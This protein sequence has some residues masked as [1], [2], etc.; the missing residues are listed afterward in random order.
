[1]VLALGVNFV[2]ITSIY[3]AS[4]ALYKTAV[5]YVPDVQKR[6]CLVLEVLTPL[7][8]YAVGVT[9]LAAP[10]IRVAS[11]AFFAPDGLQMPSFVAEPPAPSA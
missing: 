10:Y 11:L 6:A 4:H 3:R 1:M 5:T 2:E 9:S 8:G 7:V